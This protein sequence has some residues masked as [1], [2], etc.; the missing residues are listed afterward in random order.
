MEIWRI[1]DE[2]DCTSGAE[3]SYKDKH[4]CVRHAYYVLA[5]EMYGEDWQPSAGLICMCGHCK[6]L[7][8]NEEFCAY[9]RLPINI[10]P[11]A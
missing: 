11:E 5:R 8:G 4:Y 2:G 10:T 9:T 3:V 1:C 7:E 6:P